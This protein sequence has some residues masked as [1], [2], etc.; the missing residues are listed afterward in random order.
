MISLFGSSRGRR[1]REPVEG[2]LFTTGGSGGASVEDEEDDEEELLDD[3]D[4]DEDTELS[5]SS[6]SGR[7][8]GP[9]STGG[10]IFAGAFVCRGGG[11]TSMEVSF[12]GFFS[13]RLQSSVETD[14][15]RDEDAANAFDSEAMSFWSGFSTAESFLALSG[16]IFAS[17]RV[18]ALVGDK[19]KGSENLTTEPGVLDEAPGAAS[20]LTWLLEVSSVFSFSISSPVFFSC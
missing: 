12:F 7:S 11:G 19:V 17:A 5:S 18:F 16:M 6:F 3:E 1:R 10:T 14:F 2:V 20:D 4:D 8:E 13:S 15:S 9:L